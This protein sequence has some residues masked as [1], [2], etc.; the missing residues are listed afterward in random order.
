M[1][2]MI[3]L[4]NN[5]RKALSSHSSTNCDFV[6]LHLPLLQKLWMCTLDWILLVVGLTLSGIICFLDNRQHLV[7]RPHVELPV[8]KM[9]NF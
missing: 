2:E 3:S 6:G 9:K 4:A 7:F 8:M 5:A 1:A